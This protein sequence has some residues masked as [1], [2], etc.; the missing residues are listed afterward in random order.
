MKHFGKLGARARQFSWNELVRRF[1]PQIGEQPL[2]KPQKPHENVKKTLRCLVIGG[3]PSGL[4]FAT[5]LR[6]AAD[7]TSVEITVADGRWVRTPGR[8]RWRDIGE[9]T[10]R[11]QQVVTIQSLVYSR[12]HPRVRAASFPEGSYSQAWP[13]GGES[14][15]ELGYPRNVRIMDIEDGLLELASDIGIDLRPNRIEPADIDLREWDLIVASDGASSRTREFFSSSFGLPDRTPY[16]IANKSVVDT[17]LGL[18]VQSLMTEASS[19]VMTVA[20]NRFLLNARGRDGMLYMRLTPAEAAEVWGQTPDGRKVQSCQQS[21]PCRVTWRSDNGQFVCD[22]TKTVFIPSV[23]PESALWP[24][25]LEGLGLFEIQPASIEAITAFELSMTRRGAFTAE[26]T[27]SGSD[28]PVFGALLGDAAGVTHF[29]PGRGLNRGLSG[30]H[31]LARV[32]SR[33]PSEN[34]LRNADFAPF[35]AVMAAL[36]HRHQDRAWRSMVQLREGATVPISTIVSDAIAGPRGERGAM[37]DVMRDR[38]R[39]LARRLEGRLPQ[40][41]SEAEL[42]AVLETLSDETLAVLVASQAWE[43]RWSGGAEIDVDGLLEGLDGLV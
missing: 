34:P 27:P 9:G 12:L 18:R 20:Q 7:P 38:V 33:R 13:T 4:A 17:V 25:V 3:G 31:A 29:W 28:Q 22:R 8:I 21:D 40:K 16:S 35:E 41:P 10:N 30:A 23:D 39:D 5:S 37:L 24:R 1:G 15:A 19:V 36:Q 2:Q 43:T 32:L 14:P 11:R 42:F 26:L 6:L